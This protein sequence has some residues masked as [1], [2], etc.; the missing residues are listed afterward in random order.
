MMR[1][2][3]VVVQLFKQWVEEFKDIKIKY[4]NSYNREKLSLIQLLALLNND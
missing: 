2:L 1:C 4:F 3:V